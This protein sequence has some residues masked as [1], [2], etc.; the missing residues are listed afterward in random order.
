MFEARSPNQFWRIK[1]VDVPGTHVV[2]H[3][4][5]RF[6]VKFSFDNKDATCFGPKQISIGDVVVEGPEVDDFVDAA[7]PWKNAF[8]RPTLR[9]IQINPRPN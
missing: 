2:G 8:V 7:N 6:R 3:G 9:L 1:S 4:A 5:N